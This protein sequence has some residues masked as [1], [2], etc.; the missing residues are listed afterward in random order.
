MSDLRYAVRSL[1]AQ[2][3]FTLVAVLALAFGIGAT[4]SIFTV[5]NGVLLRPL[6]YEQPDRLVWFW[7]GSTGSLISRAGIA[8]KDFEEYRKETKSFDRLAGFLFG[9]WNLT[10]DGSPSRLLGVRVTDGFFETLGV[11]PILGRTFMADEQREGRND[12]VIFSYAF[13]QREFGGDKDILGRKVT[14]D[15]KT[16]EVV[17]VMPAGFQFPPESDMWAP[18][19]LGGSQMENRFR[20]LRMIG[21]IRPG[22]AKE[23]AEADAANVASRLA[24]EYPESHRDGGGVHLVTLEQEAVGSVRTTLMLFLAAV[25][26]VLLIACANVANLLL[27]RAVGRQKE[28]A[29]RNAVGATRGRLIRQL[30]VESGV[31]A[32]LGGL[33][34]LALSFAGVRMLLSL[35]TGTLPRAQEV[36]VDFVVLGFAL[37]VSLGTGLIFGIIP[38]LRASRV[39]PQRVMQETARGS[40]SGIGGQRVRGIVVVTE[41]ALSAM[42]L[43]GAGLLGRSLDRMLAEKPGFDPDNL[44]TVQV[45]LTDRSYADKNR[46]I[47]FFHQLLDQIES[48]PGVQAAGASNRIPLSGETN[49]MGFWMDGQPRTPQNRLMT[50]NRV[51]TRG[52]FHAMSAPLLAGRSFEWSDT[53]DKPPVSLVNEAFASKYFP[54][55]SA[56]GKRVTYDLGYPMVAEIIGV[57]G[58]F[59]QAGLGA[60]PLPEV[61]TPVT[62]TT[63]AGLTLVIRSKIAPGALIASVRKE[64][65]SI[66]RNVPTY[67]IRPMTQL[68]AQSIS[69]PRFRS[70]LLAIFSVAA[71]FLASLGIYG[72][73]AYSV[74]ERSNEIGIR[75]ALGAHPSDVFRLVVGHGLTLAA[76]GLAIG[77]GASLMLGR[78]LRSVLYGVSELDPVTYLSAIALFMAVAGLASFLPARRALRVDPMR[79]LRHQ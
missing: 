65:D 76:V 56:I 51:I 12:I 75:M 43:I 69:Q 37:A 19:A 53:A 66:D 41:V 77:I 39:D 28:L 59:R 7:S 68:V 17:G 5:I 78:F 42:L 29:I 6:P 15:G 31:L 21:R 38:A 33:L 45:A 18:L 9:S 73:I 34:G 58:N 14:M 67:N 23:Q 25:G 52:Y 54:G 60:D 46:C 72:V 49:E 1:R 20:V 57:V 63:I 32:L 4:T 30:L 24:R 22:V 26:L 61:Y 10:G 11:K 2:P 55:Q 70:T 48:T 64:I 3:G 8:P 40:S 62:Q 13:W 36:G 71:M 50:S 79:A 44:L 16:F 74:T 27:A 47:A 35:N